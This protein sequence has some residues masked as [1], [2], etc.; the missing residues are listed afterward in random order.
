MLY[1]TIIT[2]NL[3][4]LFFQIY[5]I[6]GVENKHSFFAFRFALR[7]SM[8]HLT[9]MKHNTIHFLHFTPLISQNTSLSRVN[10]NF[11]RM[12]ITNS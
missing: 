5:N 9:K 11:K 1:L 3:L 7:T 12:E 8:C 4:S 2:A 6:E 10:A